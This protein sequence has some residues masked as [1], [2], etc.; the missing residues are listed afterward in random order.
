MV[1]DQKQYCYQEYFENC[2]Q[3]IHGL[4]ALY[5]PKQLEYYNQQQ[6]RAQSLNREGKKVDRPSQ[7]QYNPV[8]P[9]LPKISCVMNIIEKNYPLNYFK[10]RRWR[11]Q[12]STC[13]FYPN[14]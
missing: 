6:W 4:Q 14:N 3:L 8:V 12:C 7:F 1:Q 10:T 13:N 9:Q 11:I 5:A 2:E